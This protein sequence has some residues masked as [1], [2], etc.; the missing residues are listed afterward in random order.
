MRLPAAVLACGILAACRSHMPL[1]RP[2]PACGPAALPGADWQRMSVPHSG[3]TVAM[4]TDYVRQ[5]TSADSERWMAHGRAGVIIFS[6]ANM[7]R[8]DFDT[9]AGAQYCQRTLMSRTVRLR[10]SASPG[11]YSGPMYQLVA[12]WEESPGAWLWIHG[13]ATDSITHA[14]QVGIVH[15]LR[16]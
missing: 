8:A 3:A 2:E 13:V 6:S 15:T 12:M 9:T 11:N 4:P 5:S 16:R 1:V 10:T 14:E 7:A